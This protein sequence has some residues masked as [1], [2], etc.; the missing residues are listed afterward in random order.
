MNKENNSFLKTKYNSLK[1]SYSQFKL[2]FEKMKKTM[3]PHEKDKKTLKTLEKNFRFHLVNIFGEYKLLNIRQAQ[4]FKNKF[5]KLV[6]H[7]DKI[8]SILLIYHQIDIK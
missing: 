7:K 6:G 2:K 3:V 4:K 5:S 8:F 1:E